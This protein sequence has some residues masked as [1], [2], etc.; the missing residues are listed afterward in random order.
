M[1]TIID[2]D[3]DELELTND[4]TDNGYIQIGICDKG[5]SPTARFT[6][7]H[8]KELIKALQAFL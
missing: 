6:T 3:D 4:M 1:K 2:C 8:P 7:V 5:E